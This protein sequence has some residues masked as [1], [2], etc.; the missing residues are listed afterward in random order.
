MT[1]RSLLAWMAGSAAARVTWPERFRRQVTGYL[2]SHRR[3]EGGYGWSSDA[4]AQL[5]PT[6]AAIGCY[7]TLGMNVPD[8]S[9]V[10]VFVRDNFPI[11]ERRRA[12]KD[13]PLRR[14]DFEQV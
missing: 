4:V 6:F 13:R 14:L 10:A 8:A 1:R 11:P 12:E 2:E 9:R 5:T 3:P 7:R